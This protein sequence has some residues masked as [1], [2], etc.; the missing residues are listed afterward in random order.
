MTNDDES[1]D[2]VANTDDPTKADHDA[3]IRSADQRA[4]ALT[5]ASSI[6]V[7]LALSGAAIIVDTAKLTSPGWI[8]PMFGILLILALCGFTISACIAI[9]GHQQ[10][11]E[12]KPPLAKAPGVANETAPVSNSLMKVSTK[13]H[14]KVNLSMW[15]IFAGMVF[16]VLL[17]GLSLLAEAR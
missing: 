4:T 9:V 16:V 14:A 15:F 3:N 10:P 1:T 8:R 5:A 11:R 13:K 2:D 17:T 6:A 12:G 7:S